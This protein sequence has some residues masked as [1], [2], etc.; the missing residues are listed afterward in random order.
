MLFNLSSFICHIK[1]V[2]HS[3]LLSQ[4]R[5]LPTLL[6]LAGKNQ[7][8]EGVLDSTPVYTRLLF[9]CNLYKKTRHGFS[10]LPA[11]PLKQDGGKLNAYKQ[12][13]WSDKRRHL[14][15]TDLLPAKVCERLVIEVQ[16]HNSSGDL[17]SRYI[18]GN[19]CLFF[20]YL[21]AYLLIHLFMYLFFWYSIKAV[22]KSK[23][24]RMM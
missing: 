1:Y 20:I 8:H 16:L 10:R 24:H 9:F 19:F 5:Q 23:S 15:L 3:Y 4:E 6:L 11:F 22:W 18:V 21:F 2:Q 17:S 12:I 14:L 13:L 7:M